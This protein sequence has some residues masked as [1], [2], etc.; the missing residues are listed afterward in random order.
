VPD[1]IVVPQQPGYN[2]VFKSHTGPVGRDIDRRGSR[3]LQA[4][5]GDVGVRTGQLRGNLHKE[6]FTRPSGDVGQRVGSN[7][8]Y[9]HLHHD[10][11]RPHIIRARRVPLL[12]YVNR[13][14][15]VV[16]ARSV[17]HPGTQ[18]NRYLSDNLPLAGG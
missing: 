5:R 8:P 14:G 1:R 9:A 6:W 17:M 2:Y 10:G 12:R 16:F 7:V 18:P 15:N 3:V 11:T 13:Q 4:A